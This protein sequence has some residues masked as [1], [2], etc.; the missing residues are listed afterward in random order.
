MLPKRVNLGDYLGGWAWG[1]A[2]KSRHPGLLQGRCE[3]RLVSP[4]R[5]LEEGTSDEQRAPVRPAER[6][7]LSRQ[8]R[9]TSVTLA[10]SGSDGGHS[11]QNP[12]SNRGILLAPSD[13]HKH[14]ARAP[15][16]AHKHPA[17]G[18]TP[19]KS[20]QAFCLRLQLPTSNWRSELAA[21]RDRIGSA[22]PVPEFLSIS[23]VLVHAV[24]LVR[25]A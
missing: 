11:W 25:G 2:V 4:D 5:A 1:F 24:L 15:S 21:R 22:A 20:R 18:R 8:V 12:F 6:T 17:R 23:P 13:A 3:G 14:P 9:V 10:P 19:Q 7:K 16:D